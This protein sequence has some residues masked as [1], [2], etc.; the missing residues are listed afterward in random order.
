MK[1]LSA[2]AAAAM[3]L[4][5]CA[6][7]WVNPQITDPE[8]AKVRLSSDA[9]YCRELENMTQGRLDAQERISFDPTA[10]G[11]MSNYY[12]NYLAD[13]TREDVFGRCMRGRGWRHP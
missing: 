11:Q 1:R 5:G 4:A 7:Q 8:K 6:P 10:V 2:L 9:A 12:H 3:L 13:K